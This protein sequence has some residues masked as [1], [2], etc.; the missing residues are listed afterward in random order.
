M[1]I[2]IAFLTR[3]FVFT[4][5]INLQE[6]LTFFTPAFKIYSLKAL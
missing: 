5:Y 2:E 1:L 4:D 3:N 6:N